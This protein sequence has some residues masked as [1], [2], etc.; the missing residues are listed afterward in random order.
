MLSSKFLPLPFTQLVGS[1]RFHFSQ[2]IFFPAVSEK[3]IYISNLY[4]YYAKE[5]VCVVQD[6][7]RESQF[8]GEEEA[9]VTWCCPTG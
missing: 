7:K 4:Y 6:K 8:S 3:Y 5:N 9:E 1:F 2:S